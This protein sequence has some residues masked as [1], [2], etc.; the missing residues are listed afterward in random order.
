MF[1]SQSTA[2]AHQINDE[3]NLKVYDPTGITAK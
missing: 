2:I 1:W 3:V